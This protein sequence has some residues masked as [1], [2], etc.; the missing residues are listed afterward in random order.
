MKLTVTMVDTFRTRTAI[1]YEN[2]WLPYSYRTVQVEL[3][4]E[5]IEQ[6][7]PRRVGKELSQDVYE[8][9]GQVWLEK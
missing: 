2:S 4:P 3:T 1:N 6:L 8:E 7:S 9:I 5:Q